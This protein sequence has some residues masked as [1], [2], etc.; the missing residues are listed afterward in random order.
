MDLRAN[1]AARQ[2]FDPAEAIFNRAN[3]EFRRQSFEE[4]AGLYD[5]CL[6]RFILSAELALERR[7]AAEEALRRADQRVAESDETA[8]NAELVLEGGV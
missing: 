3:T 7:R 4:A 6:P 5:E 1:V 8:R 2:E